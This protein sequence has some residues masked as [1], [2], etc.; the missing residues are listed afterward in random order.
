M[1]AFPFAQ[2]KYDGFVWIYWYD[3]STVAHRCTIFL[4]IWDDQHRNTNVN[5]KDHLVGQLTTGQLD[6]GM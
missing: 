4:C 2:I 1:T 5:N 6:V 3:G